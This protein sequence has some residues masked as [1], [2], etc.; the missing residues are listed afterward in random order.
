MSD[1]FVRPITSPKKDAENEINRVDCLA[2][3]PKP[4]PVENERR[5]SSRKKTAVQAE[6]VLRGRSV[7]MRV[8]TTD[9]SLGG[10]YTENMFTLP[11]G[12]HLT[13]TLWLGENKIKAT[14]L[15]KTC[16]PVFG[17]GIQFI[18][19]QPSDKTKLAAYLSTAFDS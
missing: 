19:I 6:I 2:V 10:C 8:S 14:G 18:D 7:P 17:N 1:A 13:I 9:L 3:N 11:M 12:A 5:Q 16:D 4:T 15:V